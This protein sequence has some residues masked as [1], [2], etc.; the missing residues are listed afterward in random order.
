MNDKKYQGGF[1][2]LAIFFLPAI[3][4]SWAMTDSYWVPGTLLVILVSFVLYWL[5]RR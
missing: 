4:V 3:M 1:H 2:L 5:K